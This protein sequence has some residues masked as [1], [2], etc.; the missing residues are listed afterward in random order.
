MKRTALFFAGLVVL[1]TS[2]GLTSRAQTDRPYKVLKTAKIGGEGYC[3]SRAGRPRCNRR[4]RRA[5]KFQPS[6]SD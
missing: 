2:G 3:I 4:R 6:K 5:P 1:L